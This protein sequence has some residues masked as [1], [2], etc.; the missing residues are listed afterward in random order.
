MA[1]LYEL[2]HDLRTLQD[3]L[4]YSTDEELDEV[5]RDTLEA[6]Q[7]LYEVKLEQYCKVIK[8]LEADMDALKNE[9]KRLTDKRKRLE[10]N[11]A[12]LKGL[13]YDSMKL[14]NT[15]KIKGQIFTLSIQKNGGKTPV[16][17]AENADLSILPD[18]LVIVTETPALDAIRELLE[19]GKTV[20]GFSLGE[21]GESL[22]IK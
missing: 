11:V 8:N 17:M 2:T 1:N 12:K 20:E 3:M 7:G 19:A 15:T 14:T 18:Q 10:S 5:L 21:R 16:I 6:N 22:R 4:E 13:M 9:A